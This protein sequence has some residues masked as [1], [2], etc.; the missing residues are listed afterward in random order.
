[1]DWRVYSK[2]GGNG[3]RYEF[4]LRALEI[5]ALFI[6]IRENMTEWQQPI[7]DVQD[8]ATFTKPRRFSKRPEGQRH[9]P[10]IE[11]NEYSLNQADSR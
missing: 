8:N 2:G 4:K 6:P 9:K 11:L 1:M 5:I 3:Q 10:E 7:G